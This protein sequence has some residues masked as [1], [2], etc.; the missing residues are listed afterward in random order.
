M[1]SNVV[2]LRP[3]IGRMMYRDFWEAGIPVFPLYRFT[4][5]GKCECGQPDCEVAGKHPRASNWQHTPIWDE[6]QIDSAEEAGHYD[7]GYG[8]ICRGLLVV[9]VDARNGG[10]DSYGKLLKAIPS[11]AAAGLAVSTGSG[12]GSQHLYFKAPEGVSFVTHH[13]DYPGIDFKSSGYVVGPGS[14]HASGGIYTADGSPDDI[15]DAPQALIDLLRR[16]ERHRT[17][18]DG[19]AIDLG[20]EDIADMLAHIPNNDA[21]YDE[22]IGIG[23]AIHHTTQGTGYGLWEVWSQSSSKHDARLMERKW[24][25]F[26][27]SANPVT[28]GTLVH[29]AMQGGWVMPV[30]F[31][32]DGK[33]LESLSADPEPVDGLPFDIAGI[34]LTKPPGFVGEVAEWIDGQSFRPRKNLAVAAALVTI[35][36]IG[37]LRYVDDR[38][39][40]TANLFAFCIAGSRTG[41]DAILKGALTIMRAAGVDIASHGTI[42][43]E[44]EIV[45]NLLRHQA[46]F[47]MVDEVA[48]F[49]SKIM[50]AQKSGGA[51]YLE[52]IPALLMNSYSKADDFLGLSGD[53]KDA[54]KADLLKELAKIESVLESDGKKAFLASR[55]DSII[56]ALATIDHGIERPF[57]SFMGVTVPNRFEMMM[58]KDMATNGFIGRSLIFNERETVPKTRKMAAREKLPDRIGNYARAIW[59]GGEYD[60]AAPFRVENYEQPTAVPTDAPACVMLEAVNEWME[61]QAE[62]K[63]ELEMES[64]YLGGYE[65]VAK[66]SLILAIPERLRTAEHVRWAFALVKRDIEE[67][68][69]EVIGNDSLKHDPLQALSAKILNHA[70]KDGGEKEGIIVSKLSKHFKKQDVLSQLGKMAAKGLLVCTETEHPINKLVSRRYE[71]PR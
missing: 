48:H 22:W 11:V 39:G 13:L 68:I 47:Y 18:Y 35:G 51:H 10:V 65:I 63:K 31:S 21:P 24:Y 32:P 12:G 36:N 14:G 6:D 28:A 45:K 9:D 5:R 4:T 23:M 17:E 33:L 69:R 40:V 34:D 42:K 26:G 37:G 46:S 41:K 15:E 16:P 70:S 66:V 27:K 58:S 53:V 71:V 2:T 61:Q 1:A 7:T 54:A 43:S 19:H 56:K 44:Q 49:F 64:L 67:K 62:A 25:S 30:T 20:H 59:T 55:R 29:H 50:N 60:S 8:V 3:Q 57:V 52:G 38:T